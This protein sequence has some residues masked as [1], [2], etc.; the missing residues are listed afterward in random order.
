MGLA[1]KISYMSVL[2]AIIMLMGLRAMPHHHCE[3]GTGVI[4]TVHFGFDDCAH[5]GCGEEDEHTGMLCYDASLFY[6]RLANDDTFVAKKFCTPLQFFVLWNMPVQVAVPS[7]P[8]LWY[9]S[10]E[11]AP[12]ERDI[13]SLALRGPPV[14]WFS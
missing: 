10:E 8:Q 4:S 6:H 2:V 11:F 13:S 9:C 5:H 1:R 14:T 12:S 3:C 7:M